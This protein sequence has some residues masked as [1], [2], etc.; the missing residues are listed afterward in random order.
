[1]CH[2]LEDGVFES[3]FIHCADGSVHPLSRISCVKLLFLAFYS[4]SFDQQDVVYQYSSF[5]L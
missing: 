2:I 5:A 3:L 4:V 1:M